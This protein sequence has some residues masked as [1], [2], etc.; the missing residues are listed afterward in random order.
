MGFHSSIGFTEVML[1]LI[2]FML[3]VLAA[4]KVAGILKNAALIIAVGVIF[5]LVAN[6]LG[7]PVA[8]DIDTVL[9]FVAAGL[10]IYFV[11]LL[12]RSVHALL[13]MTER[14]A[15]SLGKKR[16]RDDDD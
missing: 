14:R 7:F 9:F 8:A 5:P 15:K 11:Y 4:K 16:K 10:G 1:L 2:I 6:R 13:G 12:A 3:S